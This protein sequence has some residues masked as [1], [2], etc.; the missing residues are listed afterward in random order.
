MTIRYAHID[1]LEILN[2]I[3]VKSKQYW[4]Y[5]EE[6]MK[7][8]MNE[9]TLNEEQFKKQNILVAEEYGLIIGFISIIEDEANY[10]ILH[11]WILPA[12]IGKGYGKRLLNE[13][14]DEFVK[15]DK[16]ILV[17]ADPNAEP[18][19]FSQ[20]FVTYDEIESYP[21]GRFLPLMRKTCALGV[22]LR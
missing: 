3:S 10:E 7:Q 1:E 19:Y 13:A 4:N 22:G 18:F 8:W 11:M 9:L 21:E 15:E 12:F 6:W 17:E 2:K 16:P 5:P 14:I 20:G